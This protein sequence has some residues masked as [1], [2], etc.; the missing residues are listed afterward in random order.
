MLFISRSH[1]PLASPIRRNTVLII[2]LILY[3][4]SSPLLSIASSPN[5][6][7]A[8]LRGFLSVFTL[9]QDWHQRRF[10]RVS[11]AYRCLVSLFFEPRPS[12]VL[13][14]AHVYSDWVDLLC[15][16]HIPR[17]SDTIQDDT[18]CIGERH[19]RGGYVEASFGY[20]CVGDGWWNHPDSDT[21]M[22]N[23]SPVCK[24]RTCRVHAFRCISLALSL[25]AHGSEND[26]LEKCS[27]VLVLSPISSRIYV[28]L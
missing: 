25:F 1:L 20:D 22:P 10:F 9:R 7:P 28:C 14:C 24:P 6:P 5:H 4:S 27:A 8:I 11:D 19:R 16:V 17:L 2:T 13:V 15:V 18:G 12:K 23:Q 26:H 21:L 3:F